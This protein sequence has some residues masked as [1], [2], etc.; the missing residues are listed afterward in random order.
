MK[1]I[2]AYL[3][4]LLM[5]RL[6]PNTLKLYRLELET[7][8]RLKSKEAIEDHLIDCEPATHARKLSIWKGYLNYLKDSRLDG[9]EMPKLHRKQPS[10]LTESEEKRLRSHAET[11]DP[12][13]QL[14]IQVAL[15]LG[16]RI[17]EVLQL[18]STRVEDGWVTVTRKGGNEQ[19]LPLHERLESQLIHF[20]GFTRSKRHFQQLMHRI[21]K[22]CGF[23]KKITPHTLRHTFATRAI[24]N[25]DIASV[26]EALGHSSLTSTERYLHVESD[27]LKKLYQGA[28][29]GR[30]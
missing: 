28:H 29:Y 1:K 30:K 19:R 24:L 3:K 23:Q 10:F 12:Q 26:K 14:F 15:D 11:L 8:E 25:N 22:A 18:N 9:F 16:L 6:S 7:L 5:R 13:D 2:D 20:P 21:R 4:K 27:R 17:S